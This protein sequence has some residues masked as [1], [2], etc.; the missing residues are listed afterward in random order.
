MSLPR[1]ECIGVDVRTDV[2]WE[3]VAESLDGRARLIDLGDRRLWWHYPRGR[4]DGQGRAVDY[5]PMANRI[6]AE[7][8]LPRSRQDRWAAMPAPTEAP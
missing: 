3:V 5:L 6:L 2:D 8:G 1:H 4:W 7:Y